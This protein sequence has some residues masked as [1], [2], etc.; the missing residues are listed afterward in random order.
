MPTSA[1]LMPTIGE[2][3]RRLGQ[4]IH[5]VQYVVRARRIR[6]RN[7]AG[8]ARVFDHKTVD[9]IADEL[10]RIEALSSA[11][12]DQDGPEMRCPASFGLR[13]DPWERTAFRRSR[14]RGTSAGNARSRGWDNRVNGHIASAVAG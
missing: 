2:I 11:D 12:R 14:S 7:W 9:V 4:P 8:N 10:R 13:R 3:A 5:R 1:P 6:P